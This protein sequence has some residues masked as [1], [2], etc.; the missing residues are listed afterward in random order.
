MA[1]SRLSFESS[2][3]RW[4][5]QSMA[6]VRA[7]DEADAGWSRIEVDVSYGSP[8]ERLCVQGLKVERGGG[9]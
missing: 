1:S 4:R 8:G 9:A 5:D 7:E 2:S 6:G 3:S